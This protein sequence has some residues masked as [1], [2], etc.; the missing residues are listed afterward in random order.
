MPINNNND[1]LHDA[2]FPPLEED[3]TASSSEQHM[4]SLLHSIQSGNTTQPEQDA[5]TAAVLIQKEIDRWKQAIQEL[6][7]RCVDTADSK[8]DDPAGT[9]ASSSGETNI[10]VEEDDHASNLVQVVFV[11]SDEEEPAKGTTAASGADAS[12]R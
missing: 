12:S 1:S 9:Q 8:H 5:V 2:L 6:E 10:I 4:F 11:E 3:D 7:R